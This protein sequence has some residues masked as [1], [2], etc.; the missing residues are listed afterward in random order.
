MIIE[1]IRAFRAEYSGRLHIEIVLVSGV[2]DSPEELSEMARIIEPIKPD[3]VELNTVVRPPA[4]T[5]TL[6]LT[7]TQMAWAASHFRSI[8]TETVGVF[9]TGTQGCGKEELGAR[10]VETVGRRPCTIPELAASLGVP[11][12]V[13]ELESARLQSQGKLALRSFD[14]KLFLCCVK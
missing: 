10:I 6:G 4:C 14:G 1:G 2:N 5:G 9:R 12:N 13:V 7:K 3:K 8:D 11:E